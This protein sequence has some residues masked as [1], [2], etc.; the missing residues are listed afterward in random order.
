MGMGVAGCTPAGP[1]FKL[2]E[3]GFRLLLDTAIQDEDPCQ[4]SVDPTIAFLRT[5]QQVEGPGPYFVCPS[6][7]I[8][9]TGDDARIYVS[10]FAS[11][12]VTG[13]GTVTWALSGAQVHASGD[14][15]VIVAE[16]Q[17]LVSVAQS[18]SGIQRCPE[19]V[20]DDAW[21]AGCD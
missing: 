15:A 12:I 11:A 9:A 7:P 21:N 14:R 13:D 3:T 6:V 16:E 19:I 20:W 1:P 5:A 4:P 10:N 17:A 18:S 2:Q 8:T